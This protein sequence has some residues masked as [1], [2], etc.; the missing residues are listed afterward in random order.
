M[1]KLQAKTT[2]TQ[3]IGWTLEMIELYKK[4]LIPPPAKKGQHTESAAGNK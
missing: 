2:L 3:N 4:E 1:E